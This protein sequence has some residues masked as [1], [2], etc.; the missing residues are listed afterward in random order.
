MTVSGFDDHTNGNGRPD[1]PAP[2]YPFLYREDTEYAC[3][4]GRLFPTGRFMLDRT[5]GS[6]VPVEGKTVLWFLAQLGDMTAEQVKDCLRDPRVPDSLKPPAMRGGCGD[7]KAATKQCRELL[8]RMEHYRLVS[9]GQ[10]FRNVGDG[11][12]K[13]LIKVYSADRRA[14]EWALRTDVGE[15]V[16]AGIFSGSPNPYSPCR[17]YAEAVEHLSAV[18]FLINQMLYGEGVTGC[19]QS[20]SDGGMLYDGAVDRKGTRLA[21]VSVREPGRGMERIERALDTAAVTGGRL[22]VLAVVSRRCDAERVARGLAAEDASL[23]GRVCFVTDSEAHSETDA[24]LIRYT[25]SEGGRLL[26][27]TVG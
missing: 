6:R 10:F 3:P 12:R 20:Y 1:T 22:K 9:P 21:L 23:L 25:L 18:T 15:R 5:V 13:P 16:L 8:K 17:T 14:G 26:C 7:E 24:C 2:G 19:F 27:E 4:R 11:T